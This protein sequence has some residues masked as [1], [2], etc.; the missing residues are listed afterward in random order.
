MLC[1]FWSLGLLPFCRSLLC[2]G[3]ILIEGRRLCWSYINH[4]LDFVIRFTVRVHVRRPQ[5]RVAAVGAV[6]AATVVVEGMEAVGAATAEGGAATAVEAMVVPAVGVAV[7]TQQA[8]THGEN[9]SDTK[10][11]NG[12]GMGWWSLVA[13]SGHRWA[14]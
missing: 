14:S 7:V 5:A 9:D 3:P 11:V 10:L 8:R 4:T 12:I 1:R 2:S 6:A 13:R